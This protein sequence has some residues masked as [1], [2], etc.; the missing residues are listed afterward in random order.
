MRI[1][2]TFVGCLL[3]LAVAAAPAP[4]GAQAAQELPP[5]LAEAAQDEARA[6][7][8]KKAWL[9]D[10][11]W[12]YAKPG[13]ADWAF[14]LLLVR[15]SPWP[16]WH[17]RNVVV[18]PPGTRFEMALAPGQQPDRP[19]GFGT[20]ERIADVRFV[21]D[22][23]AVKTEWKPSIDRVVTFE[24]TEP[25]LADVG[26]VGPQIDLEENRYLRGGA[27][28]LEMMVPSAQRLKYIKQVTI[29]TID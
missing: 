19:G 2:R 3:S 7:P 23:L 6:G 9:K 15:Q 8:L 26:L 17:Q 11:G 12:R 21:R 14:T 24:V 5:H 22:A 4:A 27:S 20:F 13:Q 10:H 29:R 18:L 28:Q 1:A 25:L 16:E